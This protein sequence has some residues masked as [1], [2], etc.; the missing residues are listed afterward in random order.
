MGKTN[1]LEGRRDVDDVLS[2]VSS[3]KVDSRTKGLR[4]L[5]IIIK[6]DAS[7]PRKQ[8]ISDSGYHTI[9]ES[10]FRGTKYEIAYHARA[11]KAS[12]IKSESRLA[13]CASLVRTTVENQVR[14]L[15]AKT[16][17][18]I[19]DHV[20]QSLPSADGSY[21]GPLVF[22][23]VRTLLSLL[24]Y[25]PHIENFS[26]EEAHDTITFCLDLARDLGTI[27]NDQETRP[28][29]SASLSMS[30][31][32]SS[33]TRIA[34]S[35]TPSLSHSH[36]ASFDKENSQRTYPQLQS[37]AGGIVSCLQHLSS[38]PTGPI[39]EKAEEMLALLFDLLQ[40]GSNT[41]TIQ[42]PA[43]EAINFLMPRIL[44]TN[45]Q[46][47]CKTMTQFIKLFRFF[48]QVRA[49]GLKE[50]LL[51]IFLY[52]QC[53]LP[54]LVTPD[55]IH[56]CHADLITV[57]ETMRQEYCER[58]QKEMLSIEDVDLSD[59]TRISKL[60]A[61]LGTGFTCVRRGAIRAEE[62]YSLL[63]ISA[64]IIVV[65]D[66]D[67]IK[68]GGA[69]VDVDG[70]RPKRQRLTKQMDEIVTYMNSSQFGLRLYA[71]QVLAF[72]FE[73]GRFDA[74]DLLRFLDIL[75][76]TLSDEDGVLASWAIVATTR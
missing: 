39:L 48:W 12:A 10:L 72:V 7:R 57:V 71:L 65:L 50:V 63:R 45:V 33:S 5:A 18:A 40:S 62:P 20:C 34:R 38:V 36:G 69:K 49:A 11:N 13:A 41:S 42:Q 31:N 24:E 75:A 28:P 43:F 9:L 60:Q 25:K 76:S 15:G 51:S 1:G 29:S 37:S 44:A 59:Y 4:D 35:A 74:T 23:Y 47:A 46:L 19:V 53:L 52:G 68:E 16:A 3:E 32:R 21:C 22:D 27:T 2:N 73:K 67:K 64:A 70:R 14:K 56:E 58:R 6:E 8:Q 61:L 30:N 54:L 55:G 17:K 66:E 26:S